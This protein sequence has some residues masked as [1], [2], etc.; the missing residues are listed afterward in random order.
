MNLSKIIFLVGPTGVGKSRVALELAGLLNAE[1]IACDAMQVYQEVAIASDK[2]SDADRLLVR[3]HMIDRVSVTEEFDVA[4]YRREAV[5]AI[6]DVLKRDK[7][8]LIVGGSGMYVSI[9]LDG[10]FEG[11][12]EDPF[13]RRQLQE[14]MKVQGVDKLYQ[15]LKKVD[16]DASLYKPPTRG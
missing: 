8:P 11:D 14:D 12:T 7:V 3:H 5:A 1:I 6:E 4:R 16:P 10:I 13:I 9:L 15:R 2:P